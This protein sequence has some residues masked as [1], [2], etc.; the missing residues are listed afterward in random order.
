MPHLNIKPLVAEPDLFA[1]PDKWVDT[2]V[3]VLAD[4]RRTQG[5]LADAEKA[6]R[7]CPGDPLILL[8]AA[9]A[10]L[11]DGR[12]DK[13]QLYLKRYAKRYAPTP[14]YVLLLALTL[15]AEKKVIA[16][17]ALLERHDL[18]ELRT[19]TSAFPG[20]LARA[21]WLSGRL[22]GIM[23]RERPMRARRTETKSA[24]PEA[25]PKNPRP[26]RPAAPPP[27][28]ARPAIPA[29]ERGEVDIP[30]V[31][32]S[33]LRPLLSAATG[34][35]DSDGGWFVL[36]E[37]LAHLGLVEGFDE[38]I[39]VS[40]LKGVEAF[41]YQTETVRKVLKQFR[42]RVLLADEVGLGKTVEAGMVLKEYLLRG[43]VERVLVLAPASLVGQWREELETKFDVPCA[44]TQDPLLREDPERFWAQP[45]IVASLALARR[46]DH[47]DRLI[48]QSFD[49]VIVDEAHHLR[50]RASQSY[51]LVDRL[52]K[53]FL[54][55]LSATPLQNNLIEL[56][57]LLTLL[58]PGIFKT[59]KEFRA[60][61]MTAGKPRQPANP[62]RL[63]DLMRD[64][65]IRNTRAVVALKLPRRRASTRYV[66]PMPLE[67]AAYQELAAMIRAL[68]SDG[69]ESRE[70][71][72]GR[73][74]LTAAGSSPA[75]A[76]AAVARFAARPDC[77][78]AWRA[79]AER[80]KAI[81]TG[82]KESALLELIARNP[83]EK[84]L[85]FV[86]HRETLSSLARLLAAQG[87]GYARFDGG[88][89]GPDKDAAVADFRERV[90][91]LLCSE[92]GG[93]GRNI[94]FCNT[95][96][97]FDIPWNPMAIE[98][99]VGRIDRIGQ[100]RE[101]FVFN[102]VTRGTVEEQVLRL[103]D[104]KINMFELVVG[105]AGAILG[106]LEEE[107]NFA[108][109]VLDAWLETTAAARAEAFDALGR[110]LGEAQSQYNDAKALDDALFGEEFETA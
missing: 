110:R 29:L 58:K 18:T 65:M 68:V 104:E 42:G 33:D 53:R 13:A 52:T 57:N 17:R 63:R 61:Y 34:P 107:R 55:L 85:V 39:C 43:M 64:A 31:F 96:I 47:A 2:L 3:R 12:P 5:F 76:S 87:V 28:Q 32:D 103:L 19:A 49:L 89:S 7:A 56:Y 98:Q 54:L 73:H 36:R 72:S 84:K 23:G 78:P 46:K 100:S 99:R 79:L 67:Q 102:L 50:D 106:D 83:D 75:A 45:R 60:A 22:D 81:A 4:S 25:R 8:M 66:D 86:H 92:S 80:W 44:T 35:V 26:I 77:D 11:L 62:E 30:I 20:G 37:R 70:R 91:V 97:N 40:H 71:L 48:A 1:D 94:Q 59:Q 51:S 10:A 41:W 88:M 69:R 21:G 15:A 82:A 95:L 108:D 101:V 9:A 109:L 6:E 38:L 14:P 16:A 74:L 27:T 105:E 24:R 93:E 90:P